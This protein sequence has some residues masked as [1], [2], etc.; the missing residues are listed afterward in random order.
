MKIPVDWNYLTRTN[1]MIAYSQLPEMTR[2]ELERFGH[3]SYQKIEAVYQQLF[4]I[5]QAI[6]ELRSRPR[7]ED[8]K[9]NIFNNGMIQI[10]EKIATPLRKALEK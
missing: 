4:Q 8:A 10:L 2:D 5:E 6:G 3:K 7:S 1:L 9:E